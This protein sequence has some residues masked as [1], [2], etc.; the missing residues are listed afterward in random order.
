VA[1]ARTSV[2]DAVKS[3]ADKI[4]PEKGLVE[5]TKDAIVAAPGKVADAIDKAT[6][7]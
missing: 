5:K 6:T 3:V 2:H 7:K 1:D 4:A